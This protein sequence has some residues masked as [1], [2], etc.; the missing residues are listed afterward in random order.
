MAVARRAGQLATIAVE[1]LANFALPYLIYVRAEPRIGDVHALLASSLPPIVWSLVEFARRRR[2]DAISMMVLAGIVLSLLAFIGGGSVRFLQLRENLVTGL[3]ALVFLGSAAIGRPLIY[4]LAKAGKQR[5]PGADMASFEALRGNAGFERAMTVM[6]LVWGFGL[7]AE[8]V[9]ACVLVYSI[10]I[11]DYLI[12]SP[13]LGYG[14]MGA[15]ALWTVWY[16]RRYRPPASA[17]APD[18][19]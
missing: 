8:T 7:L 2:V 6:T 19:T 4:Q 12:I 9:A 11:A 1:V 15:M 17:S 5:A 18:L 16:V 14:A 13:F 10:S 3:I